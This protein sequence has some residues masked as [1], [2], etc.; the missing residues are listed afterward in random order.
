MILRFPL[1]LINSVHHHDKYEE[2]ERERRNNIDQGIAMATKKQIKDA[3]EKM[4]KATV[5]EV[6]T[7]RS[8]T[9]EKRAYIRFSNKTPAID[10]AT[11][12]GLM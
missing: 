5:E 2:R 7:L 9:G 4:F 10:I 12:L 6:K 11:T 1:I 8:I 3:V